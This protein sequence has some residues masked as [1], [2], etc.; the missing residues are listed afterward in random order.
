MPRD[1]PAIEP[2]VFRVNVGICVMIANDL[3]EGCS[4]AR[5]NGSRRKVRSVLKMSHVNYL[6]DVNHRRIYR[7]TRTVTRNAEVTWYTNILLKEFELTFFSRCSC[8][9]SSVGRAHDS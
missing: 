2:M 5:H 3:L 6:I 8:P 9:V 4:M 7:T 1:P